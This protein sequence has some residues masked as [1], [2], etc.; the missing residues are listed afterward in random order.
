MTPESE[1]FGAVLQLQGL[2][3]SDDRLAAALQDHVAMRPALER[4]RAHPMRYLEPVSEP[5]AA[6]A[7]IE[8]GGTA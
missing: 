2:V 6:L 3:L 4:L 8:S 7:W 5:G 1:M